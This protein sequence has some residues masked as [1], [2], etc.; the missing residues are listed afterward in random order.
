MDFISKWYHSGL[1]QTGVGSSGQCVP[2]AS[3]GVFDAKKHISSQIRQ[4]SIASNKLEGFVR[5]WRSPREFRTEKTR[6]IYWSK[7]CTGADNLKRK[8]WKGYLVCRYTGVTWLRCNGWSQRL[9]LSAWKLAYANKIRT[10]ST[11]RGLISHFSFYFSIL[12]IKAT[13]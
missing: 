6:S 9:L 4:D 1:N 13:K 11:S 12:A 2:W 10:L 3:L 5:H 7:G 8:D